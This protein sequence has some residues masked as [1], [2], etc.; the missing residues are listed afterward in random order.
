MKRSQVNKIIEDAIA[1][2]DEMNFKLPPFAYWILK[3]WQSK[4]DEIQEIKDNQMGWDITDFGSGDF[5]NIGLL[6]FVLRNGNFTNQKYVKPYCE[7]ILIQ[8]EGQVL[9]THFHWK[10]MEDIINRGGGTLMVAL[11]NAIS[12]DEWDEETPVRISMDG[13]SLEVPAGEP[14]EIK[15]GESITLIPRQ[16][17]KFW[18]KPGTG[19]VLLGEVSTVADE[20]ADNNFPE[21]GGRLPKIEEDEPVKYLIFND[22]QKYLS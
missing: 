16:F 7:K 9:P 2:C 21:Y 20:A 8:D 4:G 3:D 10:K 17:H 11:Y 12:E 15:P 18:A 14:F 13:R 5:D 1:F 6:I 19:K 22:Y